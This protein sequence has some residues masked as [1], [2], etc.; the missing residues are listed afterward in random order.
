[1]VADARRDPSYV[2]VEFEPTAAA[3]LTQ[4]ARRSL[5]LAVAAAALLSLAAWIF[6]RMSARYENARLRLEQRRHLTLLGEMSAVLAH[7]IRNPLA[8]LKGHAQLAAERMPDGTREKA[9]V[10]QVIA[11][12]DR[13]DA[14][15]SDLLSFARSSAIELEP[16]S[17]VDVMRMAAADV[18]D[19][20]NETSLILEI[21]TAPAI[22]PLDAGR[23]RQALINLLDN[24]RKASS[25]PRAPVARVALESNRLVFEIRDFGPGL[26]VGGEKRIFDPFFTTRT[27]GTG[28]GL[29]VASRVA[30][31]HGGEISAANHRDTGAVFRLSIPR[32]TA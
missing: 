3:R 16:V 18:F 4:T 7:E 1:V 21:G 10:E 8:S 14:L 12:A 28:L 26:P 9:C 11:S 13:L 2:V 5:A 29:A 6:V 20:V 27:N 30:E 23:V 32:P 19:V 15:T 25:G 24:A 17:P 31:M 22:W